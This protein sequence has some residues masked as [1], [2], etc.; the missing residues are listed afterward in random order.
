MVQGK[1]ESVSADRI[2]EPNAL[3]PSEPSSSERFDHLQTNCACA[4]PQFQKITKL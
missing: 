2:A 1:V 3:F 4:M